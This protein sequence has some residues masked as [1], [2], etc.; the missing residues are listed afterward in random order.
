MKF[1]AP[2]GDNPID[3][4]EVVGKPIPRI[5]GP[6]KVTGRAPYAYERNDVAPN[7][8]YG[9]VLG[10]GI[11]KGRISRIDAAD[12][13]R[14]PGVL[15]VVTTLDMPRLTKGAMNIA[16]LFA[17]TGALPGRLIPSASQ[18]TCIEFAVA[19][20]EQTP[21]PRIALLLICVSSARSSFPNCACTDPRNTSSMSTC[22]PRYSPLG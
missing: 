20:P 1:V 4:M 11:A 17:A 10:S 21:G 16:S 13:K 19:M 15:A 14:A 12:A 9:Y 18:T 7:A 22:L 2:A 3:R 5:D 8:A 6:L